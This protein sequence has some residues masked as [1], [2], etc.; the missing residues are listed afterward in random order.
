MAVD[1]LGGLLAYDNNRGSLLRFDGDH[2]SNQTID[3]MW[4]IDYGVIFVDNR[5]GTF[6]LHDSDIVLLIELEGSQ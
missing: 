4:M 6:F 1:W 2:W 3:D 5:D